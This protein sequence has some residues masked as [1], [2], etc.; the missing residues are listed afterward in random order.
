MKAI[1]IDD[2]EMAIKVIQSH[3]EK[4]EGVEILASYQ[5]AGEALLAL[6]KN[7]ADV[8]FLD[9]EMP[10]LSGLQLLKS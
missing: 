3:L 5:S 7:E 9:I 6:Q 4:L 8:L 2:E 1:I 10:G